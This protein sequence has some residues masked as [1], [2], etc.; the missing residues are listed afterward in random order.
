M[1]TV[2][3]NVITNQ[4]KKFKFVYN[5]ILKYCL[6]SDSIL[7]LGLFSLAQKITKHISYGDTVI[8]H[9]FTHFSYSSPNNRCLKKWCHTLY[10]ITVVQMT[11]CCK[12]QS[13]SN[14]LILQRNLVYIYPPFSFLPDMFSL[15][16]DCLVLE[17]TKFS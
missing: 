10:K 3:T 9:S 7:N 4:R 14:R 15:S 5:R 2:L 17:P 12:A 6:N 1:S 16:C 8:I 11:F 13:V